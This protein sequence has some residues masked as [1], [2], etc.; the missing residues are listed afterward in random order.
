MPNAYL[1]FAE[2][3]FNDSDMEAAAKFYRKVLEFPPKQNSVYGY[4]L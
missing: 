1:S 4:A 3:Y 2:Y